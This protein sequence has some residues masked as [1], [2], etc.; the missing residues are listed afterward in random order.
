MSFTNA[1]PKKH[2]FRLRKNIFFRSARKK[3]SF[4]FIVQ[5]RMQKNN[6]SEPENLS[7]SLTKETPEKKS[8]RVFFWA[9]PRTTPNPSPFA[10]SSKRVRLQNSPE[11][12]VL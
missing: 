3:G 8:G 4:H 12:R 10:A 6:I 5:G 1:V 11:A 2:F 7:L 9:Q